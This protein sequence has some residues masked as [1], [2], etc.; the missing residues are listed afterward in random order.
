[1]ILRKEDSWSWSEAEKKNIFE[2]LIKNDIFYSFMYLKTI[3]IS[4]YFFRLVHRYLSIHAL[5]RVL[6]L[7][8]WPSSS[9]FDTVV[10]EG[11]TTCPPSTTLTTHFSIIIIFSF[12]HQT[13]FR[14]AKISLSLV[15]I[16]LWF[17]QRNKLIH[18]Y[19]ITLLPFYLSRSFILKL[20]GDIKLK[21]ISSTQ[22][23]GSLEH[24]KI[25]L[26]SERGNQKIHASL[27]HLVW[28]LKF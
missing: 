3:T 20:H 7:F 18:T 24:R 13:F 2:K 5:W 22:V 26:L 23:Y 27:L 17:M 25:N 16:P 28:N 12:F 9:I 11:Q 4:T 1:M 6:M 19:W 15:L 8:T 14:R 10:F 21:L